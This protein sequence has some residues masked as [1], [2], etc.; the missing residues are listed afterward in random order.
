MIVLDGSRRSG[1]DVRLGWQFEL[2]CGVFRS[3]VRLAPFGVGGLPAVDL[4]HGG[5]AAHEV[6]PVVVRGGDFVGHEGAV[7]EFVA[8]DGVGAVAFDDFVVLRLLAV[9]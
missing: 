8:D 7:L 5:L 4:L 2:G 3:N 9:V 1:L 6:E